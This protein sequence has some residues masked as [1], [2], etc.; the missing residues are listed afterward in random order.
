MLTANRL[1]MPYT[2]APIRKEVRSG[3]CSQHLC[4]PTPDGSSR[5]AGLDVDRHRAL[6]RS[7]G[8]S[9]RPPGGWSGRPASCGRSN[10]TPL[11][12]GFLNIRQLQLLAGEDDSPARS[13][14]ETNPV[15]VWPSDVDALDEPAHKSVDG[16]SRLHQL[17]RSDADWA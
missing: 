5:A 3:C 4:N 2:S 17:L 8:L 12:P 1:T 9:G 11:G 14:A 10:L 16:P 7:A 15:V 13:V 6:I